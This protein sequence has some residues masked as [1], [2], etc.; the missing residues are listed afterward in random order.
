MNQRLA[1]NMLE[2]RGHKITLAATGRG[3]LQRVQ[4]E[5]FD[6]ILMDVQ[7]PDMDGVEAAA[8]IRERQTYR[9]KRSRADHRAHRPHHERRPR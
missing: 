3:A 1:T 7:M 2:K 4:E 5:T 8:Q 9:F 6:L